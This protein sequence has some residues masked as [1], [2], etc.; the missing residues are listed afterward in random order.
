MKSIRRLYITCLLSV[1][2]CGMVGCEGAGFLAHA[3]AGS[4]KIDVKAEYKG[5]ENQRV[6]V[7]VDA[8]QATLTRFPLVQY[9][10][11]AAVSRKLATNIQGITV[12]S[13][14]QIVDFQNRN[15]YWTTVPYADLAK[16]LNVSRI[17]LVELSN[18]AMHE[19]G[20]QYVLKGSIGANV[21]VSEADTTEPNK[22]AYDTTVAVTYPE[23]TKL[24]VVNRKEKE[25][26]FAT[27][28]LFSNKAAGKFYDHTIE[29]EN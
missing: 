15:S 6:A 11:C 10:I 8:D 4:E 23:D 20:N 9:E 22:L 19:P 12:V 25:I 14:K 29:I 17:V 5:L 3:I 2:L 28:D 27:L 24:G 21:A 7:L 1:S 26:R 13:P 16:Q 18:Y